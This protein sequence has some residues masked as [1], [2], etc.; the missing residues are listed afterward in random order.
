MALT[1]EWDQEKARRNESKHGVTFD[2]GKT[3]F[4]D[5]FSITIPDPDHSLGEDRWLDIGLSSDGRLIVVWY[6]EREDRIR[7]IGCR[8]ATP[9]EEWCYRNER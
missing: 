1:F 8:R 4:N 7:L 3:V 9:A 6:T 2:E 5:P